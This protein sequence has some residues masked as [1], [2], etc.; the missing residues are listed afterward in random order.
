MTKILVVEDDADLADLVV[1]SLTNERH[2]VDRCDNGREAL[3]FL[4]LSQYEIVILDW[5]LPGMSG[6][7]ILKEFRESGGTA[8]VIMLTAKH[9]MDDKEMG[10]QSGANDYITKPFDVR[11]LVLRVHAL[12]KRPMSTPTD[13]V[14]CGSLQLNAVRHTLI[15]NGVEIH[16]APRDYSLLEFL[17]RHPNEIFSPE[18]LIA[19][20]WHTDSTATGEVV[21]NSITRIRKAIDDPTGESV[22]ENVPR[23]GYRIGKV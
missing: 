4:R 3:D 14:V 17:M 20:V 8:G 18:A 11:D 15:R 23:V 5:N 16:L 6:P 2:T 1:D 13:T 12:L 22:I 19:R 7:A 21:R 9:T 10:F